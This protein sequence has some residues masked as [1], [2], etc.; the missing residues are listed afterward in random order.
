[1]NN[2]R[3]PYKSSAGQA[4][5]NAWYDEALR[6]I[7]F[8]Y[9]STLVPTRHGKTHVVTAGPADAPPILFLH[10]TAHNAL[11]WQDFLG[12]FLHQIRLYVIDI[13]GQ[14]GKSSPFRPPFRGSAYPEWIVDLLDAFRIANAPVVGH[15]LGG[16]LAL[17]AAMHASERISLVCAIGTAG[18][19][20][21]RLTFWLRAVDL[22]I[23][24]FISPSKRNALRVLRWLYSPGPPPDDIWVEWQVLLLRHFN[25]SLS[26]P[27]FGRNKLRTISAPTLI[28]TGAKDVVFNPYRVARRAQQITGLVAAETIENCGHLL[29]INQPERAIDR[30]RRFIEDGQ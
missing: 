24:A 22:A 1:M 29:P 23:P 15:S 13:V 10:G 16:W 20:P 19:A 18:L 2:L 30:V 17:K 12:P 11:M 26:P 14:P 6:H 4:E 21:P 5:F 8:E 3:S 9:E 28:L 27:L 7:P 25:S